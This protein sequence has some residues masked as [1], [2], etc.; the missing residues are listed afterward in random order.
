MIWWMPSQRAEQKENT[1]ID[2]VFWT[3]PCQ[4][5]KVTKMQLVCVGPFTH[6]AGKLGKNNVK[7]LT[8]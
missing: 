4:I 5:V 1:I 2:Y 8:T 3:C 7:I 6:H